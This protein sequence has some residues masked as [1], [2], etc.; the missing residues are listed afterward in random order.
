[1]GD[2]PARH[3]SESQAGD[4]TLHREV[5]VRHHRSVSD[6]RVRAPATVGAKREAGRPENVENRMQK[7]FKRAAAPLVLTMAAMLASAVVMAPT[8][9]LAAHHKGAATARH[10]A[11]HHRAGAYAG[12]AA[13]AYGAIPSGPAFSS[14]SYPGFGYGYGDN[15]HG[16]SACVD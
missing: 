12:S 3:G 7:I 6:W 11:S 14:P 4:R 5:S 16:C 9:A 8:G 15:S 13:G 10:H 2:D 1:M